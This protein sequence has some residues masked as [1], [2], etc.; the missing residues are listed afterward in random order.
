MNSKII[1]NLVLLIVT[2]FLP[3]YFLYLQQEVDIFI[4]VIGFSFLFFG[5]V[6]L[7]Y[8][9]NK[10]R[11]QAVNHKWLWLVFMV[12]GILGLC[13]SGFILFLL[14]LYSNINFP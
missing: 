13:Y 9:N 5:A 3:L 2:Y 14:F 7:T 6:F 10:Y 1:L 12:I 8:I 4:G 11:K